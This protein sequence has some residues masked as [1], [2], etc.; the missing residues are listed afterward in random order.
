[1][2]DAILLRIA[3]SAI[4]QKL[5]AKERID[6][7]ALVKS[8]PFLGEDGA[9]FVT[10][11]YDKELRGCIGSIVPHRRLI[12]DI[13]HN[14]I[15]AGFSDPRFKA[16]SED[17]L[18]HLS[19][20]VSVLSEPKIL[21]YDDYEDLQKKVRPN[22]DGLILKH[23]IYQGTFLPQVWEQLPTPKLFLE[24]LSMKAGTSMSVYSEHPTLYRYEVEHIK[25]KFDKVETL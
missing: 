14:A 3:K 2:L 1:M 7:E 21:E 15:S 19:L 9:A 11:K 16:L 23:G 25:D 24:H 10:L 17:E 13:V 20:E 12:D 22:V 5:D 8:Y 6:T 4:L 18:K